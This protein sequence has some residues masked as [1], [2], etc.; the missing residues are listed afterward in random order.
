[1]VFE[2]FIREPAGHR[3]RSPLSLLDPEATSHCYLLSSLG[4]RGN[5]SRRLEYTINWQR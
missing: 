2:L 5:E 1:M 3:G 4:L